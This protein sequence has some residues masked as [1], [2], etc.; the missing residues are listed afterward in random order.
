[1]PKTFAG[2]KGNRQPC[3]W[4]SLSQLEAPSG[5][6]PKDTSNAKGHGGLLHVEIV[7]AGTPSHGSCCEEQ[8]ANTT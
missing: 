2:W 4:Y 5:L 6:T 3:L 1:M 7:A 8:N